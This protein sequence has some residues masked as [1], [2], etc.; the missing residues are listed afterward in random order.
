MK[1]V[2][3]DPNSQVNQPISKDTE[4]QYALLSDTNEREETKRQNRL[5]AGKAIAEK[6]GKR[7]MFFYAVPED[8]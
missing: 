4:M 6:Y 5:S 2:V 8:V 3:I 7:Q 1:K